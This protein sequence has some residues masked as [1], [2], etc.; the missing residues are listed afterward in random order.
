[1]NKS[2]TLLYLFIILLAS[3]HSSAN[4]QE[5]DCDEVLV[6]LQVKYIGST[7]LPSIICGEEVYLSV[8]A[9]FDFLQIKNTTNTTYSTI[10]GYFTQQ[11][12]SFKIDE[13]ARQ[14]T[15]KGRVIP[16]KAGDLI[17]TNTNLF[18]KAIY[19]NSVFELENNFSFRSLAVSMSSKLELPAIK[20]ARIAQMRA[21]INKIKNEFTADTTLIRDKPLFHFGTANW[22][23][24]ATQQTNGTRSERLLLNLGGMLAGGEL[25]SAINYGSNQPFSIKNQYYRWRYVKDNDKYVSQITLGKIGASST[26]TILYPVVGGQITNAP[27]QIR[28]SFG[29]YALSDHTQPDWMVELYINNVLV[30]YVKA[31]ANGFFSFNVPLMYGRTEISLRYYGPW[32][33]E[34]VSGKQFVIPFNFLPKKK[35]EYVLSS[36]IIEDGKNSLFANAKVNYG[37]SNYITIGG[38]MEYFSSLK[39][40]KIIPFF[41]S[42]M[43]VSSQLF[44]SGGYYHKVM[45]NGILNYTALNNLRLELDYTKYDKYQQAIRFNYS[46]TRKATLSFPI[47][48]AHFSG[49]SRLSLQQNVYNTSKYTIAESLLSGTGYG[50]NFNFTTN[51]FYTDTNKPFIYS[52]L[53]TSL[54]L[55]KGFVLIPQ[56]RYEYNAD[57][58]TSL[59]AELKKQ[60][61]RKGS[62]QASFDRNFKTSSSYLQMGFRYDFETISTGFSSSFTKNQASFSQS[63]SGSLIYEPKADFIDFNNKTSVGRASMKFIPFLDANGNGKRDPN[64]PPV[65]GL[66]ILLNGGGR[67]INSKDGTTIITELEPYIKNHV[68]LN[69]NSINTIAWQV[70]N[71]TLNI[72]LN[73]NQLKIIEIP[74]VVVGEVGGTV[75]RNENGKLIGTGGLKINIYDIDNVLTTTILSEPDGYFSFLGLKSGRYSAKIDSLQLQ[76]L[77]MKAEPANAPF[78]INNGVD[79]AIVDNIEF[80]LH[81]GKIEKSDTETVPLNNPS[82]TVGVA[83][84][85]IA[86]DQIEY[87]KEV[88]YSVQLLS[89]KIQL[90]LNHPWFKN[91]NEMVEYE[92]HGVYKYIWGSST[93]RSEA[94]KIKNKLR[95]E[96]YHDAFVVPFYDHKRI[97]RQEAKAIDKKNAA[98]QLAA[99]SRKTQPEIST[100]NTS[101]INVSI[102]EQYGGTLE[103]GLI[104]KTQLLAS[105]KKVALSDSFFKGLKDVK[106]YLHKGLYKYTIGTNKSMAEANKIK[107]KLRSN[108]FFGAFVVPFNDNKRIDAQEVTTIIKKKVV[109]PLVTVPQE[110]QPEISIPYAPIITGSVPEQY[111]SGSEEGLIFK[112][113]LLASKKKLALTDPIFKGLKGIKEYLHKKLYKYT[114]GIS[115]SLKKANKIKNKLRSQGFFGTFVVPFYHNKRTSI[116]EAEAI[117]KKNAAD[118]LEAAF[119]KSQLDQANPSVAVTDASIEDQYGNSPEDGLVFKNQLLASKKKMELSDPIFKGLKGIKEYRHKGMYKYTTGTSKSI[120]EANDIRNKLRFQGFPNAFVVPFYNDER[121]NSGKISGVVFYK[122][123]N[124]DG[125]AGIRVFIYDSNNTKI[126]STLSEADGT[127]TLLGLKPGDYTAQLDGEQLDK[128]Q[129][130][131]RALVQKFNIANINGNVEAKLEFILEAKDNKNQTPDEKSNGNKITSQKGLVF[132]IQIMASKHKQS[133]SNSLFKALKGIEMYQHEGLYKYTWGEAN[134]LEEIRKI[135]RD[136]Q[137]RGIKNAFII[138]FYN[139]VRMNLQEATGEVSL[140]MNGDLYELGGIKINIYDDDTI[141]ITSLVSK[142]DGHFS[143]LGLRPGNYRAE[144]DQTQLDYLKMTSNTDSLQFS[145]GNNGDVDVTELLKFILHPNI[146]NPK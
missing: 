134:T 41:N 24:N 20:E 107:N 111:G 126:T 146:T 17:R 14:I 47:H 81:K 49:N 29:T 91:K 77:Q 73:P 5:R 113:Q 114:M 118:L 55:P 130:I 79:G 60:L 109:V 143:F 27:T 80:V 22:A 2:G 21:N 70:I 13:N 116:Q 139:E 52:N 117:N 131:P 129:M 57:G 8:P 37:L 36:G 95:S 12:N 119:Q 9:V 125:I 61:F 103:E 98:I 23:V 100:P 89:S 141:F 56:L 142:S 54:R 50:L 137:N 4:A 32:G 108:G 75:N 33:E 85:E 74:V 31:D 6:L 34:Q 59:R 105:K 68:E 46:E 93:S 84:S 99:T 90:P 83:V 122:S 132:K 144:L 42:S 136:L 18:L 133:F 123:K 135:K 82:K 124:L 112:T 76:K 110:L 120:A 92:H 104:F 15:Y 7:E 71:K 65:I 44:I 3:L 30:D 1:M 43:R 16:L 62:V 97:S 26:S 96:G 127:F 140:K 121:I 35:L 58:I 78:E 94:N 88:I 28:K 86:T 145:I 38:G 138:P 72:T 106:E 69:T 63:A 25:T 115:K 45:Y 87:S 39:N 10:E 128:A 11:N 53:S 40:N 19:F 64:E 101:F 102:E 48:T 51:L 66:Q 67:Q